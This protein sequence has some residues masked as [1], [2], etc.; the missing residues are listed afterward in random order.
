M[1]CILHAILKF[2]AR[3]E[4]WVSEHKRRRTSWIC[5][6]AGFKCAVLL[7]DRSSN[8]FQFQ[9]QS[10]NPHQTWGYMDF[11]EGEDT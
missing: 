2:E 3:R 7:Q 8:I 11:P 5:H 10:A 6:D 1:V 4:M 9:I